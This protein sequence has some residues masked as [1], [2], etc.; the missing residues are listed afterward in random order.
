[1]VDP[2]IVA[3]TRL[4]RDRSSSYAF[5][6]D[7]VAAPLWAFFTRVAASADDAAQSLM[8]A[9]EHPQGGLYFEGRKAG[10]RCAA[11]CK[12][13]ALQDALWADTASLCGV[14]WPDDVLA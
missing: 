2:G 12:D 11:Q 6:F 14:T 8:A 3:G 10:M 9:A 5:A 13:A 1:V 4:L 7:N